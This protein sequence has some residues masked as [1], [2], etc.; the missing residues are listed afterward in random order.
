MN[1]SPAFV[2][3]RSACELPPA[4]L[5]AIVADLEQELRRGLAAP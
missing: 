4:E 2:A 1:P 5:A 3:F